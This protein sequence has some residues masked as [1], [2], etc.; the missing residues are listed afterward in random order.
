MPGTRKTPRRTASR[1]SDATFVRAGESVS[2]QCPKSSCLWDAAKPVRS[3][4]FV[5]GKCLE[6]TPLEDFFNSCLEFE[7]I[8]DQAH[9]LSWTA[10]GIDG[11]SVIERLFQRF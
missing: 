6:G 5:S 4:V 2:R 10:R 7:D 8:S 3:G 11:Q 9:N 1:V